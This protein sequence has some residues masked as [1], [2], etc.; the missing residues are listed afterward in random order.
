MREVQLSRGLVA[1]VDDQDYD[2]IISHR[3]QPTPADQKQVRFYASRRTSRSTFYMHR[4]ILNPPPGMEVD[5][6]NGDG[7]DN[8][9]CNLRLC[10]R[11]QNNANIKNIRRASSGFRGVYISSTSRLYRAMIS[12][13]K[14]NI[15]LGRYKSA[16]E[17]AK[18]YDA[19][20][21]AAFGE[22]ATL[23]FPTDA[24]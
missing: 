11:G 17:A 24:A 6:I 12:V 2:M 14:K 1:L 7:L 21:S 20:A 16:E 15:E 19:A 18:A 9:R 5:H 22:F 23:N 4:V 13:G 3:W 10:S 8:R